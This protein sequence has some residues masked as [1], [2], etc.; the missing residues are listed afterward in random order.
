M[1]NRVFIILS[2]LFL[3]L[4]TS[5]NI[6]PVFAACETSGCCP[7]GSQNSCCGGGDGGG[8]YTYDCTACGTTPSPTGKCCME[9]PDDS[10][11]CPSATHCG[12]G[13]CGY[14]DTC[15]CTIGACSTGDD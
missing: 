2:N 4:I 15:G 5:L 11:G 3:L 13:G 10:C 6:G 9:W 14:G 12:G 7:A 8:G 1:H